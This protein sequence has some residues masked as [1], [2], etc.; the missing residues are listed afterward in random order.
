MSIRSTTRPDVTAKGRT[1]RRDLMAR[2]AL[3]ILGLHGSRRLTHRAIDERL[4]YPIGTT[5]AYFRRREDLVGAA[6][7]ALFK[8]DFDRFDA[9]M[10][11]L[12]GSGETISLEIVVQFYHSM[13]RDVRFNASEMIKL[14]RYE[15]FLLA[16][17]DKEANQLLMEQFD[18][19]QAMDAQL[20]AKLGAADPVAAAIRFGFTIRGAFFTLAFLPEPQDRLD[21]LDEAFVRQEILAAMA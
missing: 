1:A 8:S 11:T 18:A 10:G 6:V 9:A 3:E 15:C 5:S 16:R 12:F 14:A 13:L 19:R 20:F 21:L 17:R 2:A 7:R 4:G